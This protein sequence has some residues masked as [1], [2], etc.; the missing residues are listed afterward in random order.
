MSFF[1]FSI[2]IF[3]SFP[4]CPYTSVRPSE[5]WQNYGTNTFPSGTSD[6][7]RTT[8]PWYFYSSVSSA[9]LAFWYELLHH[10]IFLLRH[11][12]YFEAYLVV[13]SRFNFPSLKVLVIAV[14]SPNAWLFSFVY[15]WMVTEKHSVHGL[16][17]FSFLISSYSS[18]GLQDKVSH[19]L[20]FVC[21]E[22]GRQ[23]SRG[24][25]LFIHRLWENYL[26][27]V[28]WIL[29]W[30]MQIPSLLEI[31]MNTRHKQPRSHKEGWPRWCQLLGDSSGKCWWL[32]NGHSCTK[33]CV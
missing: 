2:R 6:T 17:I 1:S 21:L 31:R 4:T 26:S 30:A 22:L 5:R 18:I 19:T 28:T 10:K 23:Y 11:C 27:V 8:I 33:R 29:L 7:I 20:H 15:F 9:S 16:L 24:R 12:G 14:S 3:I 32:I 25:I 13:L